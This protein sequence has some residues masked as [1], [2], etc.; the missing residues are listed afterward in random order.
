MPRPLHGGVA[1][2]S[3]E[4]LSVR[5][6]PRE[7]SMS[8]DWLESLV[9]PIDKEPLVPQDQSLQCNRC[10][11]VFPIDDGIPSFV[12]A[13]SGQPVNWK[14]A[15]RY[16]LSYWVRTYRDPDNYESRYQ[17]AAK[18][19]STLL[20]SHHQDW[21]KRILQIGPACLGEIH[22][23]DSSERYAVEPLAWHLNSRGLLRQDR[24]HW[25]AGMGEY[26]PFPDAHFTVILLS[27][28]LDH[29][30][31][32][33]RVLAEVRRCLAPDGIAWL[34]CHV[35]RPIVLPLFRALHHLRFTY[36]GGHPWYYSPS[37]LDRLCKQAGLKIVWNLTGP[38]CQPGS[39][40]LLRRERL[41]SLLLFS[42]YLLLAAD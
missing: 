3:V 18:A 25:L 35:S 2:V 40:C 19:V 14:A 23:L 31:R 22:F 32:P 21:R 7:V 16:E 42:R 4:D 8:S 10:C 20:D 27:N 6:Q 41:K 9:C 37:G 26:L 34:S 15:Q 24:V 12:A 28:V 39:T 33:S 38:A 36:F 17:E 5:P 29:V 11:R 13:L 30:A 1:G